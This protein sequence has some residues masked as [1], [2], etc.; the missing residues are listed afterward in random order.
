ME[1]LFFLQKDP[2]RAFS[3]RLFFKNIQIGIGLLK[4]AV[5]HF[6]DWVP[7]TELEFEI[8]N[9]LNPLTFQYAKGYRRLITQAAEDISQD[10]N[11]TSFLV[12]DY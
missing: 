1:D 11:S 5:Q 4:V 7:Q 6:E 8:L 10:L 2:T 12:G 9:S 3:L